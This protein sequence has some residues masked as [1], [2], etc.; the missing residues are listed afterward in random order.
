M[1]WRLLTSLTVLAAANAA[2]QSTIP[3]TPVGKVFAGWLSA[4][5]AHDSAALAQYDRQYVPIVPP[6]T[7]TG[8]RA[9]TGDFEF[10]KAMTDQPEHLD[11]LVRAQ[12]S[13]MYFRGVMEVTG[14]PPVAKTFRMQAVPRGAPPEGCKTYVEPPPRTTADPK[15]VATQDAIV[16]AL[17]ESISGPACQRR[18]WDRFHSL[19]VP[20][21]RLIPTRIGPDHKATT[22]VYTPDEY[23]DAVKTSMDENGFFE[24]EIKRTAD[25]F[26]TITEAFSTYESRR[27]ANDSTPFARGINS[28][29]MLNDGTRWWVVTVYWQGER[30]D[31]PIPARYLPK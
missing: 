30:P 11:F 28:I 25:T 27:Q 2:A 26:G 9:N 13:G 18:D 22:V 10:V 8:M 4:F 6:G 24:R 20:G 19:F 16:A 31:M 3:S 29:Q 15:D 7:E 1:R 23:I 12:K 21:A 17:Y 14:S 5:N